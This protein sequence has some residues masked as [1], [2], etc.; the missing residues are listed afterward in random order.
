[1]NEYFGRQCSNPI[2]RRVWGSLPLCK[3]SFTTSAPNFR[4]WAG[5]NT[6]EKWDVCNTEFKIQPRDLWDGNQTL[7]MVKGK[8]K[9]SHYTHGQALRLS[10]GW[11]SQISWQSAHEDNKFVSPPHRPPLPLGNIPGT[12]LAAESTPGP[13]CG[14]NIKEKFQLHHRES[15][16]RPSGL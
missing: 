3:L 8:V 10:G 4:C 15:N 7:S 13:H 1:M 2:C 16:P 14:R 12:H 6:N 9:Q 11:D 5:Q